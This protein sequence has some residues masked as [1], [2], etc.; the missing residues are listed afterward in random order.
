MSLMMVISEILGT[1]V[2]L[3]GYTVR[4]IRNAE[5]ILPDYEAKASLPSETV[6]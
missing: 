2:G 6:A 3:G 4:V 5:D 1:F